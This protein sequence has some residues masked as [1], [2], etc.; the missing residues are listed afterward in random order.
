MRRGRKDR[1]DR[2]WWRKRGKGREQRGEEEGG[3]YNI[4]KK[5]RVRSTGN[6]LT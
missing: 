5:W 1:G 3:S 4:E 2:R 6:D